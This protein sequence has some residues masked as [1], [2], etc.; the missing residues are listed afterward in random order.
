VIINDFLHWSQTARTSDRIRAANALGIAYVQSELT[1]DERNAAVMA[2]TYMLDDPSPRVRLELA[3]TIA[4]SSDA[5]R[6]II[7]SLA[8][9]Q[10]E[11][12]GTVLLRS[13]ILGNRDLVDIACKGDSVIRTFIANRYSVARMVSAAI[14]EIG[15]EAE[16]EALLENPGAEFSGVTLLRICSRFGQNVEIRGLLCER[17]DLPTAGRHLLVEGLSANFAASQL[18]QSVIGGWNVARI[19][20]EAIDGATVAMVGEARIEEIPELVDHLRSHGALTPSFLIHAL[21]T[22]KVDFFAE[23]IVN[24]TGVSADHVRSIMARGGVH[25]LRALYEKAGLSADIVRIF[26]ETTCLWRQLHGAEDVDV[27]ETVSARLLK[28]FENSPEQYT[29]TRELLDMVE[30]LVVQE[31]RLNARTYAK[32]TVLKAA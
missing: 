21:C 25:P 16:V 12:A 22:G 30:R 24:L 28:I 14:C 26:V 20:R 13:P 32:E 3:D 8:D 18:V 5:P 17:N 27:L 4:D 19:T 11:I 29:A 23:V 6:S 31:H 1:A 15:S 9:D 10:P 7:L 2:M